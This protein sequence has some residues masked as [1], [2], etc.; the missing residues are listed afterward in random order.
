MLDPTIQILRPS[1]MPFIYAQ[2]RHLTAAMARYKTINESVSKTDMLGFSKARSMITHMLLSSASDFA[3]EYGT[4]EEWVSEG[5]Y[6][7]EAQ[8]LAALVYLNTGLTECSSPAGVMYRSLKSQLVDTLKM[9]ERRQAVTM[10][11]WK[12]SLWCLFMGGTLALDYNE[13]TWF[14]IRIVRSMQQLGLCSWPEVCEA[15]MEIVWVDALTVSAQSLWRRVQDFQV[16]TV[17]MENL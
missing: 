16:D 4:D 1:H 6:T 10:Y 15:L 17:W 3:M 12:T 2:L 8:R 11:Q 9:A 14:A 7:F 13:K 5:F